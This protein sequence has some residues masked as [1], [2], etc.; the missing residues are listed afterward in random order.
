MIN[1]WTPGTW[2]LGNYYRS[3]VCDST[4]GTWSDDENLRGYGAPMICESVS[5]EAN[6]RLIAAAPEM[7]EALEAVAVDMHCGDGTMTL[8]TAHKVTAILARIRGD[9]P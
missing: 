6:A 4:D 7:A 5:S 1:P 2:R 3:I 8:A 9:A